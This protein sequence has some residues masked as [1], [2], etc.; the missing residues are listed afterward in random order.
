MGQ[1]FSWRSLGSS[2][3]PEWAT[4][5]VRFFRYWHMP[6]TS[7]LHFDWASVHVSPVTF[8]KPSASAVKAGTCQVRG[9]RTHC[10]VGRERP[11]ACDSFFEICCGAKRWEAQKCQCCWCCTWTRARAQG[12]IG[13]QRCCVVTYGIDENARACTP[14]LSWCPR[15]RKKLTRSFKKTPDGCKAP[16][17]LGCPRLCTFQSRVRS[18]NIH[19]HLYCLSDSL[20]TGVSVSESS[21]TWVNARENFV[22]ERS[23]K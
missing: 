15:K 19:S 17:A 20:P 4:Q 18:F 11:W 22:F 6:C 3:Q 2:A 23:T 10:Q 8:F 5:A 12:A 7:K 14:L 16:L 9:L 21:Y 13:I 1:R